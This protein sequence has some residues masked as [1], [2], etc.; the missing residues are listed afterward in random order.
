MGIQE[1]AL[2]LLRNLACGKESDIDSVF[3][4]LGDESLVS[5]LSQ[6][7]S[8]GLDPNVSSPF[9]DEIIMQ[10]LYVI[11]NISTGNERHKN[12]VMGNGNILYQVL[13]YMVRLEYFYIYIVCIVFFNFK[14][15]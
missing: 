9:T 10:S 15:F 8:S 13:Q 7:L 5:I 4:A 11:V 2:N 14:F 12:A 6:K 1:Q 3:D